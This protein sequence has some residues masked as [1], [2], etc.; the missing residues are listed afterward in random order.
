MTS[1]DFKDW[2]KD[3][4]GLSDTLIHVNVG[5][6]IFLGLALLLR[7]QRRGALVAWTILLALESA[8][9]LVDAAIGLHRNGRIDAMEGWRDFVAT[10]FWP[11][12]L[13][14]VRKRL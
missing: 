11:T 12:V 1:A 2:F 14:L 3:W 6:A 10:M 7:K 5:L 8:N 9:E 4:I 13:L